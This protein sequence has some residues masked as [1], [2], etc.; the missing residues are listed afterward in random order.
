[1]L[2]CVFYAAAVVV[3][4]DM[5]YF[6]G[7][8]GFGIQELLE[9]VGSENE[10]EFME[11]RLSA[12]HIEDM[13]FTTHP[14]GSCRARLGLPVLCFHMQRV[15]YRGRASASQHAGWQGPLCLLWRV[16]RG[17]TLHAQ[18]APALAFAARACCIKPTLQDVACTQDIQQSPQML[19]AIQM[20]LSDPSSYAPL[21]EHPELAPYMRALRRWSD[22]LTSSNC[23]D[24]LLRCSHAASW[25]AYYSWVSLD[26]CVCCRMV[27][28]EDSN[29]EG[30]SP[31]A[32]QPRQG[33]EPS[34]DQPAAPGD[35]ADRNPSV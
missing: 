12:L 9:R 18:Q 15:G 6:D 33:R 13:P 28:M 29:P 25:I 24:T 3:S 22:A 2:C 21:V 30:G 20:M 7:M 1:M 5:N 16:H 32:A 17:L 35:G 8:E 4:A 10:M 11:V 23:N 14:C 19:D 31:A 34:A 26:D 27:G